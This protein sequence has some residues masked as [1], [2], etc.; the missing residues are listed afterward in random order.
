P[1]P[2]TP[3]GMFNPGAGV[4][5]VNFNGVLEGFAIGKDGGIHT[6]WIS[7]S[8]PWNGPVKISQPQQP[9]QPPGEP[10]LR[11]PPEFGK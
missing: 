11:P 8:G 1:V 2:I 10:P 9:T 4:A 6:S 5:M 3:K 7:G